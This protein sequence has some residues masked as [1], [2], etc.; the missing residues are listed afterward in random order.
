[1]KEKTLVIGANGNTGKRVVK[2][3]LAKDEYIPI[4]MLRK[5]AQVAHFDK[6]G[7]ESRLGDLEEDFQSVF[8]GI[9]N[10]IF[11]AGSGGN[12]GDNKTYLVDEMGAIK[13]IDLAKKNKVHKFVML[14]SM[15]ID[16]PDRVKGL[17][18]YLRAKK[19]A[20]DHLIKSG[21]NYTIARPGGLTDEEGSG[22]IEVAEKLS[23]FGEVS[24]DNVAA[25]L[26]VCLNKNKARN[27]CFEMLDGNTPIEKAID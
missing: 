27:S 20:D 18:V 4:A 25:A 9:D 14:S 22:A 12:T 11:A 17:E 16:I 2:E 26:V 15:G 3:L 19:K 10:V 23:K 8:P 21:L 6:L 5:E 13:A 7:V 24:R 1:M